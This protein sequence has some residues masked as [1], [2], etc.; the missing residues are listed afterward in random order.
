MNIII[1]IL[2]LSYTILCR[3]VY[4]KGKKINYFAARVVGGSAGRGSDSCGGGGGVGGGGGG[5]TRSDVGADVTV[6]PSRRRHL[7]L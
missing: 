3:G 2:L 5:I 4:C 1:I 7:S 6:T